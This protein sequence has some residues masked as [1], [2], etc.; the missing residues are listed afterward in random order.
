LV[1]TV[2]SM[3]LQFQK[4]IWNRFSIPLVRLDSQRIH[5]IR[6]LLP[7]NYNPFFYHDK[8]I[9]SID[10]LKNDL[11]YRVNLENAR[12]D[13]IVID[14]AHNVAERGERLA[15]RARLAKLLAERSDSLIMLTATPHDGRSES[16]ASLIGML[17]P[18]AIPDPKNY[19]RED[20]GDLC[21]R[22]HKK[23]IKDEIGD[24]FM[25]RIVTIEGCQ[26][27]PAEERALD[28]LSETT[29]EM[30][31]GPRRGG[32][33]ILFKTMLEKSIFSSPKACVKSVDERLSKLMGKR[34]EG[35]NWDVEKLHRL[36]SALEAIGPEDFSRYR[37][38]VELLEG[39]EYGWTRES[40]DRVVIF[41]ERLETM[42]FIAESLRRDISLSDGAVKVMHGGLSDLEQQ[43]TVEE[44]GRDESPIRVLVASDVASEG[45]NLHYLCHRLIHFDIPWSLMVYQQRNGRVDRYGQLKVPDIRYLLTRSS[46]PKIK[47]DLRII[48]ILIAKEQQAYRNIGDLALLMGKFN[49]KDEE[50]VTAK[51]IEEGLDD[52]RF[53]RKI[54][55]S[56]EEFN[57]LEYLMSSTSERAHKPSIAFSET[58]LS[59]IDYLEMGL[60]HL[61]ESGPSRCERMTGEWLG[62]KIQLTGDMRRRLS[63]VLTEE[64][65]PADGYLRL[66]PDKSLCL[67][68]MRRSLRDSLS[69][70]AW[71]SV[72]FLWPL[73]PLFEWLGERV[74]Q[75]VKRGE[76]PLL[77]LRGGIS[78]NEAIFIV[79]GVI[80]NRRATPVVDAWFGLRYSRGAFVEEMTMEKVLGMTGL[81][82]N[83]LPNLG[84]LTEADRLRVESLV[85]NAVAEAG[86]VL[87]RRK[88][89]Y[90]ARV[91]P[92]IQEELE[93][94]GNLQKR[95]QYVLDLGPRA[96]ADKDKVSDLFNKFVDF[97]N[98]SLEI[99]DRPHL[100]IIAG[101]T[102]I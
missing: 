64:V 93:R 4:E 76:A 88:G 95:R 21:V 48:E 18:T 58:L 20:V 85:P 25:D 67:S 81:R 31:R 15:K 83:D 71:P 29:F 33:E 54:D 89:E 28:L 9:I 16:F 11:D 7:A 53:G 90:L 43:G 51:A 45:I 5:K 37:R 79:S 62:L 70:K 32:N 82:R 57:P 97:V 75:L 13:V 26:A 50:L 42:H 87:E 102:G 14:E 10:T 66:S 23:D 65:M 86:K 24:R 94:L 96:N 52:E 44:F 78:D 46:N 36:R 74:S 3:M 84:A 77:G 2:K 27:S 100:R 80:A 41:T 39:E 61:G 63:A 22:R 47:G 6:L 30:D 99:S 91:E 68:E 17:D 101:I 19:T 40:D 56:R 12:W 34:G 1:V 49:I 35:A 55:E 69:E 72:Q 73:H 60:G 8:T 38:L 59:D 92:L 98:E